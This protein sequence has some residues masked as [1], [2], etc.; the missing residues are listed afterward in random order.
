MSKKIT[1]T[2]DLEKLEDLAV[3]NAAMVAGSKLD[4]LYYVREHL[5]ATARSITVEE[6]ESGAA[7][8]LGALEFIDTKET[9]VG[10]VRI[11]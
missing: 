2:Y 10:E 1:I 11:A 4:L 3:E 8:G 9:K 6:L 7:Y 5:M